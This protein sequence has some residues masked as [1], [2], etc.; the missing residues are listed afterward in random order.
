MFTE[1]PCTIS[2]PVPVVTPTPTAATVP[3]QPHGT[4]LT[5]GF[6]TSIGNF[7]TIR[8]PPTPVNGSPSIEVPSVPVA[9]TTSIPLITLGPSTV[10][11]PAES[12]PVTEAPPATN[13]TLAPPVT[14]TPTRGN[15]AP[16]PS[17]A[18]ADRVFIGLSAALL[19]G[20]IAMFL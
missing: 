17:T 7:T 13:A 1:C 8:N 16:R 20:T 19:S 4:G 3:A 11:V 10:I 9:A 6:Y 14:F 5:T 18:D 12:T 15:P 2:Y